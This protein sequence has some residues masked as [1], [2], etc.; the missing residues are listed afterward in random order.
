MT[1]TTI[2]KTDKTKYTRAGVHKSPNFLGNA[3][4]MNYTKKKIILIVIVDCYLVID[5]YTVMD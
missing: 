3:M 2:A 5:L 4:N 1:E